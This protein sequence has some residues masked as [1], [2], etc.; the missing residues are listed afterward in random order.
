LVQEWVRRSVPAVE[1]NLEHTPSAQH[2][3]D[4]VGLA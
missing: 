2:R 3:R 4:R 1:F